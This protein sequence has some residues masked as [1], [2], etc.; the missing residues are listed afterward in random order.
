MSK[1]I[2]RHGGPKDRGAA[3]S[4][5]RRPNKPHY[6]HAGSYQSQMYTESEMTE[7]EIFMYNIGF[8]EQEDSGIHKYASPED[9]D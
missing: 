5:Y 4:Y 3:D 2:D 1:D 9:E 8:Q 7:D 6:F